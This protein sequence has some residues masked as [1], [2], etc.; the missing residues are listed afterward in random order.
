MPNVYTGPYPANCRNDCVSFTG[1]PIVQE[2]VAAASIGVVTV[3][4]TNMWYIDGKYFEQYNTVA[5][6]VVAPTFGAGANGG[7]NIGALT[8]ANSKEIEITQGNSTS[9]KNA[10]LVGTSPA[11]FVRATFRI[12]TLANATEVSVGF[13]KQASYTASPLSTY[14]DYAIMG[15][16]LTA[17][18]LY[19]Q[20]GIASTYVVTDTT[21]AV[22]AATN[23]TIQVNV[24]AAGAVTY[25]WGSGNGVLAAPTTTVAA[26]MGA[27]TMIPWIHVT[28]ASGA[29]GEVDLVSYA[30]GLL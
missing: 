23:F 2:A 11:F 21:Q 25:L 5:T 18:E 20:T 8:A 24:S 1:L 29:N 12:P 27:V 15:V 6:S 19:T 16:H 4:H 3:G 10:F 17:G 7:L 13:R 26:T 14:T 22:T 28:M 9:I 30:C